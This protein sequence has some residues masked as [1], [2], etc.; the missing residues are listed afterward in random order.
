[1]ILASFFQDTVTTKNI[2]SAL[3]TMYL[4]FFFMFIINWSWAGWKRPVLSGAGPRCWSDGGS[5]EEEADHLQQSPAIWAGAGFCRDPLPRYHPE[6]E[7]G[8]PHTPA[9][10]QDTGESAAPENSYKLKWRNQTNTCLFSVL[11]RFKSANHHTGRKCG[12]FL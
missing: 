10:E 1:M 2:R 7:A 11:I 5:E 4:T 9:R 12:M 3:P 6:G 8:R